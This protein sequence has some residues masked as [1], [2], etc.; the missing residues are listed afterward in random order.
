MNSEQTFIV[1][2]QNI[3]QGSILKA[4]FKALQIKFEEVNEKPY[5]R[6]FVDMVL[7]ADDSIKK[8]KGRKVS[9]DEFDN[10]WK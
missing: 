3:E 9:S 4:F 2:P 5:N 10:L 8:G 6:E 1:H 7:Q